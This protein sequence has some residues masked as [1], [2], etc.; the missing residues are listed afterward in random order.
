[1]IIN[2]I[3]VIF[4]DIILPLKK[5]IFDEVLIK[6]IVTIYPLLINILRI[7]IKNLLISLVLSFLFSIL[8]YYFTPGIF[9]WLLFKSG[10]DVSELPFFEETIKN[11]KKLQELKKELSTLIEEKKKIEIELEKSRAQKTGILEGVKN[12]KFENTNWWS[13]I[14]TIAGVVIVSGTA[15]YFFASGEDGAFFKPIVDLMS[16]LTGK[17]IEHIS[18]ND[19]VQSEALKIIFKK[20]ENVESSICDIKNILDINSRK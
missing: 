11:E 2:V 1:M 13:V 19:K 9:K 5:L 18:R 4:Y 15:V 7:L 20:I 17:T 12:I 14:F 16:S 6:L 8:T 10:I 3:K